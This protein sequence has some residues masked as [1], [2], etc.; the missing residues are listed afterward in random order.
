MY[1]KGVN[2]TLENYK[3]VFSMFSVDV[4]DEVRSAILDDTDIFR[5]IEYC[6]D[7]SYKLGQFRMALR[8]GIPYTYLKPS[9][10]AKSVNNLRWCFRHNVD[11][12]QIKRYIDPKNNVDSELIESLCEGMRLGAC[13]N[14]VD[15]LRIP[16]SITNIVISGL[17]NKYPMELCEGVDWLDEPYVRAL[18][19]GMAMD[20]DVAPFVQDKWDI[21]VLILLFSYSK[22]VNLNEFLGYITSKFNIDVVESLL[23][24]FEKSIPIYALTAKDSRG[25]PVYNSYQIDVLQE[26]ILR[27][28]DMWDDI[29]NPTLSD[30]EMKAILDNED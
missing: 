4:Q 30:M 29:F 20:V 25:Y 10:T 14:D 26:A 24:I 23:Q 13:I 17:I 27:G 6:G 2:V 15:F 8:E 7:D 19:R 11:I 16:R 22:R 18:M 12:A 3:E 1:Y 5:C 9:M 21:K 28:Y